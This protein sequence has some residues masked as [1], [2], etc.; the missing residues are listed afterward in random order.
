[1]PLVA[2]RAVSPL[3]SASRT[4]RWTLRSLTCANSAVKRSFAPHGDVCA[5]PAGGLG[6]PVWLDAV[7]AGRA[8]HHVA[9]VHYYARVFPQRLLEEVAVGGEHHDAVGRLDLL[10]REVDGAVLDV[11]ERHF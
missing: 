6:L 3:T 9:R 8:R 1:M 5:G 11:V 2:V 4:F 7:H 10:G